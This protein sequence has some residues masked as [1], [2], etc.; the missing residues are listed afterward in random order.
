LLAVREGAPIGAELV[1]RMRAV[2]NVTVATDAPAS[3]VVAPGLA[4]AVDLT[5]VVGSGDLERQIT[6]RAERRFLLINAVL[7]DDAAAR[8]EDVGVGYIDAAGRR[9]LPGWGRTKRSVSGQGSGG[10]ALRPASIRLA[11]LLAD[12]PERKW[13]ER[14]LAAAGEATQATAHRLFERLE[15]HEGL[16]ERRGSGR[17]S[18]R[19]VGDVARLRRWLA[20]EAQPKR[21]VRLTCFVPGAPELPASV[22]GRGIAL[23]GALAA[24]RL[25]YPVTTAVERPSVRVEADAAGIE[26]VPEALGGFRTARGAN[27]TL[28]ADRH[29]LG[30]VDAWRKGG[31]PM[32]APPSRVMLD[33]YLEPRGQAAADVFLDLWGSRRIER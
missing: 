14:Q 15:R 5:P 2:P 9:W 16:V 1:E 31:G 20:R 10:S 32:L 3:A 28:I 4:M 6:A 11:Q 7:D 24:E 22:E 21:T 30:F 18:G 29:R 25:G 27:L 17:A 13:T 26:A 23:T 33:M 19:L 8:L 12:H